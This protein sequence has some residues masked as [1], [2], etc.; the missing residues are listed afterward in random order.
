MTNMI[1]EVTIIENIDSPNAGGY[2]YQRSVLEEL[3]LQEKTFYGCLGAP[4]MHPGDKIIRMDLTRISHRVTGLQIRDKSLVGQV[5]I[6][7]TPQGKVLEG[8]VDQVSFCIIGY[9]D[10]SHLSRSEKVISKLIVH[11][12]NAFTNSQQEGTGNEL[13]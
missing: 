2:L 12:I 8:I 7:A 13:N 9:G 5:E 6:L 11:S 10:V 4:E 1:K 3:C